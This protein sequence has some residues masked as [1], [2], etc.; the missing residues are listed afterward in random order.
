MP[1][2]PVTLSLIAITCVVSWLAWNRPGWLD[3][4][5]LWPP[6]ISRGREYWRFLSYGVHPRRCPAPAV[7]Y[8]HAVFLREHY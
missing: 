3:R 7:Q 4:L 1:L 6:A 8:D 2:A 5:I